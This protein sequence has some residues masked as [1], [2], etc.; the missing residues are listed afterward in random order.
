[1]GLIARVT[2]NGKASNYVRRR[3]VLLTL[4]VHV[5][6]RYYIDFY[7]EILCSFINIFRGGRYLFKNNTLS[8]T[9]CNY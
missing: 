5:C 2:S 6:Y 1:M 8:L 9:A 4:P 3:R 7:N